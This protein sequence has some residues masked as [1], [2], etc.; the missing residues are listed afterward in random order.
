MEYFS[1]AWMWG[2]FSIFLVLALC[3]DTLLIGK[4]RARSKETW[5]AALFWTI[6][7]IACALIFNVF[8]W[9]YL[10]AVADVVTAN[11]MALLFLTAYLVEKSLSLDNLF[12]FYLIF[13][14][15]NIPAH[16]QHRVLSYG[17]WGAVIMRLA[18]ILAGLWLISHF[19][20][21]IY[22]MGAFLF[23]TGVKI[24]IV[25]EEEKDLS[26]TFI[27]RM[28]KKLFRVTHEFS[29]EQFFVRHN[30]LLYATPLFIALIFIE[31]SDL[32]FA[33]D[34]I[35]AVF[36]ITRDPFIVWTS[37]IFAIL[38]LRAMYFLLA[39]MVEE[40]ALLKYG[41]A[42]ILIYVGAKMMVEP[43]VHIPT[44]VSL[45]VIFSLI[46]IFSIL[47]YISITFARQRK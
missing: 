32:I 13:K 35:P 6:F 14:H 37:N 34:S 25:K 41:I 22:V 19:H 2:G 44:G 38:G 11:S 4:Y 42:L 1:S 18:I 43:W 30:S 20:W 47:S 36:A 27:L 26:E 3:I 28:C 40:L 31:F 15:F 39:R 24:M 10:S 8:I 45:A 29:G 17:I 23:F 12:V 46:L 5:R 16:L 7:W 33:V 21:L 9:V